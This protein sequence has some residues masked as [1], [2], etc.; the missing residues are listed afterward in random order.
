[1]ILLDLLLWLSKKDRKNKVCQRKENTTGNRKRVQSN[2][3]RLQTCSRST[4]IK[5]VSILQIRILKEISER[6]INA[7]NVKERYAFMRVD[8]VVVKEATQE[9]QKAQIL[10][11]TVLPKSSIFFNWQVSK[12]LDISMFQDN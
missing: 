8:E 1:M 5:R 9:L 3:P 7:K 6:E 12:I 10:T 2:N 11:E 4:Q